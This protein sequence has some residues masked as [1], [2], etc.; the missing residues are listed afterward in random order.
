MSN[1]A[2][3]AEILEELSP[4]DLKAI[5]KV[6]L[7]LI[8]CRSAKRQGQFTGHIDGNGVLVKVD[9]KREEQIRL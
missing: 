9:L 6:G 4:K 2:P 1:E 8:E 3:L 7:F 5:S